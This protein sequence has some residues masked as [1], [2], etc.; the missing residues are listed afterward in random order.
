MVLVEPVTKGYTHCCTPD[1]V[2]SLLEMVPS[3]DLDTLRL[4]VLRQPTRKQAIA[5]NVW[6]RLAYFANLGSLTGPAVYL[7]AQ[8]LDR[9]WRP[10]ASQSVEDQREYERLLADGHRIG[11]PPA[12]QVLAACR[13]T[14]L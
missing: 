6:G 12:E 8:E 1:D 14:Q 11:R 10:G 13:S 3:E 7:E 4:F 2:L 9:R 5:A